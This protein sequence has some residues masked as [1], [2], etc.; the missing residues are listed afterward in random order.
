MR[1]I[2]LGH[3]TENK[4]WKGVKMDKNN[5]GETKKFDTSRLNDTGEKSIN[6]VKSKKKKRRNY[7]KILSFIL[8]AILTIL[9]IYMISNFLL[10]FKLNVSL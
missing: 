3:Y 6:T 5:S 2:Y 1:K 9:L 10:F 8:N 7:S 4:N